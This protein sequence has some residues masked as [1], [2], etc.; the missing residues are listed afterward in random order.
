MEL[1]VLLVLLE[2]PVQK[3]NWATQALLEPKERGVIQVIR[4]LLAILEHQE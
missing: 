2:D 4:G 1:Q 3:E